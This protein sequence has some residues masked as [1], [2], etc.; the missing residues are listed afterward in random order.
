MVLR[1]LNINLEPWFG[2]GMATTTIRKGPRRYLTIDM[3][4]SSNKQLIFRGS[5]SHTL[6]DKP[7][8][9]ER[10]LDKSGRG[11]DPPTIPPGVPGGEKA[12]FGNAVQNS[13]ISPPCSERRRQLHPAQI[14][15]KL[16]QLYAQRAR[17]HLPRGLLQGSAYASEC[18][19]SI[20]A[21]SA[22]QIVP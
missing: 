19:K 18:R 7:E 22:F 20:R 21:A 6:S 11:Y 2:D 17:I 3:F 15:L 16:R 10:K 1:T 13:Q 5:S 12:V 4:D 9:N 14:V 8:K